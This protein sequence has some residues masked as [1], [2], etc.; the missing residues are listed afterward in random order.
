MY[1]NKPFKTKHMY[2]KH[3]VGSLLVAS[4]SWTAFAQEVLDPG[5]HV[6]VDKG[7][8]AE[9]RKGLWDKERKVYR[10][11]ELLTIGMPCGGIAAG[12]LYVRG[13]G[14]LGNW[15]I[16]NNAYNTGYGID[17]LIRFNTAQ[18]PWKVC[19]Q[20]FEPASY[21]DQGFFITIGQQ[22]KT[23]TVTL[24]KHGFDDISFVG[25]YPIA[26]I[27]YASKADPL[28]VDI[29]STVFSPFI[30]MNARESA[31]PGTILRYRIKNRSGQR[32][33]A[34]LGGWLQNFVCVENANEVRA[35]SY[36]RVI[37]GKGM[38]SV[39]M[40]LTGASAQDGFLRSHPYNGDLTLSVLSD[41][42][43]ADA[44][45]TGLKDKERT[46]TARKRTGD[47]LLGEVG[48]TLSL[49]PGESREVC[50]LLTWY[51][52][53]RPS[54]YAGSDVTKV[55]HNNWN[56][57]LPTKGTTI[58]G[59]MYANWYR[60]SM[61]VAAWLQQ[62]LTRLS[63]ATFQFHDA[64]Y[65]HSTLPGWLT[66]RLLMPAS[67]LATETC[68]WW[69]N[70]KFWA[71]EGVGSCVGTCTHVWN[72]EQ[73]L[74]HLFPALE[75]NIREKTD[76][77]VSFQPDGGILSRNG[78]GGVLIDG[79]AG[80]ILKAYREYLYSKDDLFL[81]RNWDRI[82]RAT[83]FLIKEDENEDGLIEKNQSNTFDISFYGANTYVGSLYLAALKAAG[84]MA[85]LMQDTAFA[86][87]CSRIGAAGM[88]NAVK[89]LWNGEYFIQRVDLEKHPKFQYAKGCLSDQLF[90]QTWAH[91]V[92]LGYIYPKAQAQQAM[93]SVW[94]YNWAPDV[95]VQNKVH[96]PERTY[97]S[98]GEPGLLVCTWPKSRH[99]GEDGVRYRDEVWTGSE[100]QVATD[101][102][103]ENMIE[104]GL[105]IVK[106]VDE[107]YNPA[108]HNPWNEVECGDHY[109]RAM[110]S[111]GVLI[112]LQNFYYNGPEKI[113]GF[114][115][116]VQQTDFESFFTSAEAWGN[117]Q[118]K[119]SA[120]RQENG[121]K[122]KYGRLDLAQLQ[123][124]VSAMPRGIQVFVNGVALPCK[125]ELRDSQLIVSF[126]TVTLQA[127]QAIRLV[128][129]F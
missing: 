54:Y 117:I 68:Q 53:N 112:A 66:A 82:K 97:A 62:N 18:G 58:L 33:T 94:K 102:I 105:S 32:V 90:G 19:Y 5:H 57:A 50:F 23:R 29:T 124:E 21:V 69:A 129:S 44:E 8:S 87:Q 95:A 121:V 47:R 42:A 27:N 61:D 38:L 60:S 20:T 122:V 30:P 84:R 46:S 26:K 79:H 72:Y 125:H 126:D 51:F 31:T 86:G 103:Y 13:D 106:G 113:I 6:P 109:A 85:D 128:L 22:G 7:L 89:E 93:Q 40:G 52:P 25:E 48:T 55:I 76:L 45:F 34:T 17:S 74:A 36:N 14:T 108:K 115:P 118:Q 59:N 39:T 28:P 101:M 92:N 99:P 73:A 16:A 35:D 96:P 88:Q 9:W 4:L 2:L 11:N 75:R 43:H 119:R 65:N 37:K 100:Y 70:D 3:L 123:V 114:S 49:A 10:G 15:W 71:W 56:E 98:F 67:I 1:S 107:R 104:E 64:Y 110:A 78:W 41:D 77:D 81:R 91:L 111:W 63:E 24:D 80:T 127:G 120:A 83:I 116:R 12:Q